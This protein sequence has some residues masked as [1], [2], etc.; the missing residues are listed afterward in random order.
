M[1]MPHY[2][3]NASNIAAVF[4]TYGTT[5]YLDDFVQGYCNR[6]NISAHEFYNRLVSRA[7]ID[8]EVS[9]SMNFYAGGGGQFFSNLNL[10][11]SSDPMLS[12]FFAK[13]KE[14]IEKSNDQND[15]NFKLAVATEKRGHYV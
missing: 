14:E 1:I 4:Y 11:Y 2:I 8:Y 15:R 12:F 13:L 6:K 7:M 10:K 3:E 9:G 5:N